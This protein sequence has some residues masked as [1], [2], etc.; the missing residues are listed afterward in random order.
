MLIE[1]KQID[2]WYSEAQTQGIEF[3]RYIEWLTNKY[4]LFTTEN[5]SM[6]SNSSDNV[7]GEYMMPYEQ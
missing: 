6:R 1:R 7:L 3:Y 5:H 2:E 4:R